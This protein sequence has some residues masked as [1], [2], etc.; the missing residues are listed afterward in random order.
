[1]P[2]MLEGSL[3][4]TVGDTV[5]FRFRVEHVGGSPVE[6]TF[7]DAGKFDVAVRR[8]DAEVWRWSDGRMFAQALQS[9]RFEPGEEAVFEAA[10]TDPR[11]GDYVAEATLRAR[12]VD[13][14]GA[15]S[16]SV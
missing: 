2:A 16:F 3:D 13:V 15:A 10:W 5:A 12:Q 9:A 7:R 6:V 8:G 11:P 1:M 14:T 4:V